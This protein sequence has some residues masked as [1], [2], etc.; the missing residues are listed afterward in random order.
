ML[1]VRGD[2]VR[3]LRRIAELLDGVPVADPERDK[4]RRDLVREIAGY[5]VPR[6]EAPEAPLVVAFV[7]GSGVGKSHVVNAITGKRH[8]PEG[9][10]RPTTVSPMLIVSDADD[11]WS[12]WRRRL[13][14]AA[15]GSTMVG[16]SSPVTKHAILAD[17]PAHTDDGTVRRLHTM[18]DLAV[19][20]TT[21]ARYADVAT[22][23]LI[24]TR[25]DVGQ[26]VWIV[27][28]RA[29]GADDEV[30]AD[31]KRRLKAAG[32]YVPVYLVPEGD[33]ELVDVLRTRLMDISGPDWTSK[34][35]A[36]IATRIERALVRTLA[37]TEPLD[38]LRIRGDR[39]KRLADAEYLT[40]A[41][42]LAELIAETGLG[43]GAAAAPWADVAE[44]LAGVVTRRVGVAAERTAT[45]WHRL[46]DGNVL[47]SGAGHEL[48]RHPP[49]TAHAARQRL[50]GWEHDVATIV[51]R[52]AKRKLKPH[53]LSQTAD[54][55]RSLALGGEPKVRWRINRRLREGVVPAAEEARI[56]L[57][58]LASAIVI[59][60]EH[61]FLER[62]GE[63]PSADLV[64]ELRTAALE[65]QESRANEA[66]AGE[67]VA[68]ATPPEEAAIVDV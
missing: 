51:N 16:D 43:A 20:V 63:R 52:R 27:V 49:E 36:A 25:L 35:E 8:S 13:R 14:A 55:V 4:E 37:L 18:A 19:V 56:R 46:D 33:G 3:R 32:R 67:A 61:R 23:R 15:P 6:L 62:M 44:R 66:E 12:D 17:L 41:N 24:E 58:E 54:V 45:A 65:E 26:P 59:D 22:W 7:G 11:G 50:L 29:N 39:L 9:P 64:D 28:N 34:I 53:R 10:L 1:V 60:D 57:S 47:L 2:D 30:G 48:W 31:L 68:A 38:E 40:A 42:A 21:P 5:L